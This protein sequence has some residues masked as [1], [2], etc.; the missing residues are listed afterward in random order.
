MLEDGKQQGRVVGLTEKV[1]DCEEVKKRFS[2][3]QIA[4]GSPTLSS[5]E[6][7]LNTP[8]DEEGL[9]EMRMNDGVM[10]PENSDLA[11][12]SAR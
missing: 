9:D 10:S 2:L 6:H 11:Q 1:V 5:C 3:T 4:M 8:Q 7:T 12:L